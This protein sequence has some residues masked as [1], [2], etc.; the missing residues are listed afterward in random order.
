MYTMEDFERDLFKRALKKL[1]PEEL[2]GVIK[3]LPPEEQEEVLE[4]LPPENRL[5]GLSPE[6]IQAYL[7]KLTVK[8]SAKPRRRKE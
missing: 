1:K 7:D 4:A 2:R 3:S 6:Q 5:K 8:P